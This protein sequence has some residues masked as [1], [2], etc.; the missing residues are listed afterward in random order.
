MHSCKCAY[1]KSYLQEFM[2][3]CGFLKIVFKFYISSLL[4]STHC[5]KDLKNKKN[6]FYILSKLYE[7][8]WCDNE[9]FG[10]SI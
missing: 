4:L 5:N 8:V 6:Q 10:A 9:Y 1:L 7:L 2:L 3:H